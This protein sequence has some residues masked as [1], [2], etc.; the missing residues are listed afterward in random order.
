MGKDGQQKTLNQRKDGTALP[1]LSMRK[2]L[3]VV[4]ATQKITATHTGSKTQR[5]ECGEEQPQ[6]GGLHF[7]DHATFHLAVG[8][9]HCTVSSSRTKKTFVFITVSRGCW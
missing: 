8:L 9:F 7:L 5:T 3:P 6:A 2:A 1:I 4:Q